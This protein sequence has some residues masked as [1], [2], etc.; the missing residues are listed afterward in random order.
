MST[1]AAAS[2]RPTLRSFWQDLPREGKYLLSTIIIDFIG[3]GLV[4]PFNV[5]YLHEVRG[6]E[7]A[8]V[9]LLSAAGAGRPARG[10]ADRRAHRPHRTAPGRRRVA[11][12]PDR[13]V[14]HAGLGDHRAPGGHR[15]HAARVLRRH[16][17]ARHPD[18]DRHDHPEPPAAALLRRQ[19]HAAQPR[20][21]DRRHPRRP[22][23]RRHPAGDV[24]RHLPHRRGHVPRAAGDLPRPA[25]AC[26]PAGQADR[27][28]RG[29][30]RCPTQ[31]GLPRATSRPLAAA[32]PPHRLR[33]LVR[34]LR[35]AQHRSA[36]L[37][38]RG[39]W[40]LDAGAR[41]GLR[42]QHGGHRR[43]PAVRAPADRRTSPHADARP[44]V[45]H[46][47]R[48]VPRCSAPPAWYPAPSSPPSCSGSARRSSGSAR[49]STS[50]RCRR[51]STTSHPTTCAVATTP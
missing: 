28:G 50:R 2:D 45:G 10:G 25:A 15:L 11:A 29:P 41:P 21:R 18:P 37:R 5:V 32:G 19:L 9:G 33:R 36:R 51:W 8:R 44:H 34:G 35:A 40:H 12:H 30:G 20:H 7:L 24:R 31:H 42:G 17:L 27:A 48:V 6:F 46:L 47:G 16:H 23:R 1:P 43:A 3:N 22:L 13:R 14:H 39:R 26:P 49:R 38:P 4:M